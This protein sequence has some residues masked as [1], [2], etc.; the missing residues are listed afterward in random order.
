MDIASVIG[1]IMGMGILAWTMHHEGGFGLYWNTAGMVLVFGGVIASAF[2]SYPLQACLSLPSI[3]KKCFLYPLPS[4]LTE[5]ERMA[6]YAVLARREGLLG[7]EEKTKEIRDPFLSKGVMLVVD[8]F[9]AES[10]REILEIDLAA[11]KERHGMAKKIVD[12]MAAMAPG[13]GMVGTLLGL[14][15]MLARLSDPSTIGSSMAVS[16]LA[17]F[18]GAA[19]ANVLFMPL[20][21]KLEAR[22]KEESLIRQLMI[23][24]ILAIQKGDKPQVLRERL[25]A[26]LTPKERSSMASAAAAARKEPAATTEG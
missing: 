9:S 18:Y 25:K 17:T 13:Y 26:F 19:G 10:V 3:L 16:L 12:N 23:E 14:V 21:A 24:G 7:L 1:A 20:A 6:D 2:L 4:P 8:G 15:G 22:T 5:I 11:M